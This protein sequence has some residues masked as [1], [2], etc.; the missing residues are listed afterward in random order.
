M[1]YS[2]VYTIVHSTMYSKLS[3]ANKLKAGRHVF[4]RVEAVIVS[5]FGAG[6]KLSVRY[7][8]QYNVQH[9]VQKSI[10]KCRT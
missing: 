5:H 4:L 8:V 1:V 7:S 9:M 10:V 6:L 2:E 3:V